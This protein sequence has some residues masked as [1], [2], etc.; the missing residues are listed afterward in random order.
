MDSCIEDKAEQG[1]IPSF[2]FWLVVLV[3]DTVRALLLAG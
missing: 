1:S 2:L 3:C